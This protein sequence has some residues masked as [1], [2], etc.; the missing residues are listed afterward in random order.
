[1][2]VLRGKPLHVWDLYGE[3]EWRTS[4]FDLRPAKR[5]TGSW[6]PTAIGRW[7]LPIVVREKTGQ[8]ACSKST[9]QTLV[10]TKRDTVMMLAQTSPFR[11]SRR[12][13]ILLQSRSYNCF[14]ALSKAANKSFIVASVS[15][16]MFEMRK[17][18]P[19]IFP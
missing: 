12:V 11:V 7:L 16:P 1:M 3:G 8:I 14:T 17:V 4:I 9:L 18:V 5:D 19:L 6:Q 13:L 2:L 10:A 15:S